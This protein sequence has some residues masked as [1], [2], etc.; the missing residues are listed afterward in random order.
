MIVSEWPACA[1]GINRKKKGEKIIS[2]NKTMSE[3]NNEEIPNTSIQ[4]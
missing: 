4:V 1:G 2:H 3:A